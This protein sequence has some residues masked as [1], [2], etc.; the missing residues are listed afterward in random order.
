MKTFCYKK[1]KILIN[2]YEAIWLCCVFSF[3]NISQIRELS[4]LDYITN[5]TFSPHP[6]SVASLL[7]PSKYKVANGASSLPVF[8]YRG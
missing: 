2:S 8:V 3:C 5:Y 7:M 1:Y 6:V 4:A